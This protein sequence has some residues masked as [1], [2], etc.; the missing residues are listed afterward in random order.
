M[1][2]GLSDLQKRIVTLAY[3]NK[4]DDTREERLMASDLPDCYAFEVLESVYGFK[5]VR[6]YRVFRDGQQQFKPATPEEKTLYPRL[7]AGVSRSIKRLS[8]RGLI[9]MARTRS[10]AFDLTERGELEAE[11]IGYDTEDLTIRKD[12]EP[13][14]G[15]TMAASVGVSERTMKRGLIVTFAIE[16]LREAGNDEYA[17]FLLEEMEQSITGAY[18]IVK[19][20]QQL[21]ERTNP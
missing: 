17:D 18:R 21:S 3:R 4:Y 12:V 11:S 5:R 1:G 20:M 19:V 16:G 7:Q 6:P 15:V 8:D 9:V 13:S 2:R 14:G 10:T